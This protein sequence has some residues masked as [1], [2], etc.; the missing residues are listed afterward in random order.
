MT[1]ETSAK[2]YLLITTLNASLYA[3][4]ELDSVQLSPASKTRLKN[5]RTFVKNYLAAV[6]N[7]A[8]SSEI[9]LIDDYTFDGVAIM[10]ELNCMVAHVPRNQ[11]EWYVDEC[12]KLVFESI[13]RE[14]NEVESRDYQ[15][16]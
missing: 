14:Q 7:R 2:I 9:A 12:K 4:A 6:S 10:A 3:I 13:N 15:T 8:K 5:L 11:L 1:N 16:T